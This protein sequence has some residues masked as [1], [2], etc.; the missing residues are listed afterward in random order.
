MSYGQLTP[1]LQ[2]GVFGITSA[3][4]SA[5]SQLPG[6]AVSQ[7]IAVLPGATTTNLTLNSVPLRTTGLRLNHAARNC[8]LDVA[9]YGGLG[10][11]LV[12]NPQL[13]RNP[14]AMLALRPVTALMQRS[15]VES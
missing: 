12:K 11:W 2:N 1:P 13:L 9:V 7:I 4:S 8:L 3:S 10:V 5:N 14:V 6:V 15:L